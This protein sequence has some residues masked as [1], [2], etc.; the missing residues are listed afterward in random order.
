MEEKEEMELFL[1][2]ENGISIEFPLSYLLELNFAY[3]GNKEE[4]V[5]ELNELIQ[6][7]EKF[8]DNL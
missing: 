4:K 3:H 2:Q 1:V 5:K 6:T 7:I 8:R